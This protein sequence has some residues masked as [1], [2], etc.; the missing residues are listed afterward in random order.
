MHS[1]QNG[2]T[3]TTKTC[4][5]V[6]KSSKKPKMPN[7]PIGPKIWRR[8]EGNGPGNHVDGSDVC[9]DM[10]HV[11]TDTKM[12]KNMNR[13]VKM[14]Q[15]RSKWQ[16]SLVGLEIETPRCPGQCEHVSNKGNDRYALQNVPIKDLGTRI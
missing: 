4:K 14:G 7:S 3:T 1:D 13:K 12:A 2:T 8:G 6:S 10:Q 9:R 16:N 5:N 15:R 11:E